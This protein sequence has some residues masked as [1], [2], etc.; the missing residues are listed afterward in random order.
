[1]PTVRGG[2]W[3]RGPLS[4]SKPP[5]LIVARKRSICAAI[6][7]G[8]SSAGA[9]GLRAAGCERVCLYRWHGRF[10]SWWRSSAS[11]CD[12]CAIFWTRVPEAES[13]K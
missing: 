6:S 12:H 5:S 3:L 9:I 10:D 4:A 2:T 7:S 1:M 11:I 8:S 13:P